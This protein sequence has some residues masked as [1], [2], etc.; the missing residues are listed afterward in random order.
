MFTCVL[1]AALGAKMRATN[2][3]L[4]GTILVVFALTLLG[5]FNLAWLCVAAMVVFSIGEMLASPKYSEFLGNIA[6]PDKKAMWIG[7]SQAPI[8]IGATLEGK[9]GPYLYHLWSD[10][11]VCARKMLVAGGMDPSQVKV[12]A[13][14]VGEAFHKLVEVT[15]TAPAELTRA[16]YETNRIGDTWYFFAAV[17]MVSAILIWAYGRWIHRLAKT[18][19]FK[20]N[21]PTPTSDA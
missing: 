4:V 12:D 11:D 3:L 1:F 6:P 8:L 9:V 21:Q 13:L 16:L 18:E 2:S 10:K 15:G 19:N 5:M 17:G 14:P 7:F 20:S